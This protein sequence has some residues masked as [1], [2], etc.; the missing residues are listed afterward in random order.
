MVNILFVTYHDFSSN[1]AI[2]IHN[3]ANTLVKTG[4]HCCVAVPANKESVKECIGGDILYIPLNYS[5]LD[6]PGLFPNGNG[7][8]II[9]AWTPREIV[10]KQCI[11]SLNKFHCKLI[12]HLEDNEELLLE[13]ALSTSIDSL[14]TYTPEKLNEIIPD[15]LSHLFFYRDFI[16]IADGITVIMDTLTA[17]IPY[18]KKYLILWPGTDRSRFNP[19]EHN[20]NLKNE[21]GIRKNELILC[22]TGNVHFSNAKEVRSLYLA[23][24]LLNREGIPTR[25]I[26]TGKDFTNFL[27]NNNEWAHKFSIEMGFLPHQKISEIL[28]I[29]DILVQ[30]GKQDRFNEFRLPSKLPEFFFMGKPVILPY[31]N[32]GRFIKNRK[33]GLLLEKGDAID[34]VEK[35]N[36]LIH[37]K[38]LSQNIADG[39]KEFAMKKFDLGKNTKI[40]EDFYKEI[41]KGNSITDDAFSKYSEL[42]EKYK[43]YDLDEVGYAK[44]RDFCDSADNFKEI[45]N[46]DGDLKNVQRSWM[47][48]AILASVPF[49]GKL[50]EIGAGEPK[51]ADLLNRLGYQVTVID[52][53]EGG[54]NGPVE[55]EYFKKEY[56]NLKIIKDYFE[57]GIS[58][59]DAR[60]YDCV[61]SISVLEHIPNEQIPL[62]FKGIKKIAKPEGFSIHCIDHVLMGNGAQEHDEKLRSILNE[63]N[64]LPVFDRIL[65]QLKEDI[66]TYY[67]SAEGHNLWRGLTKYDDFP[68]RK[69]VSVQIRKKL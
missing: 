47:I 61:Y 50:V 21:L 14:K 24:A 4:N 42:F 35:V 11:T 49:G 17:F 37:D 30:P 34:I 51:V 38:K 6:Q 23:V 60:S 8:D 46:T 3:F 18:D 29:A 40:L 5:D 16:K 22:Y 66:E 69:V 9:H 15:T 10:R 33:E 7:P 62:I 39:G 20:N 43:D 45:C 2:Q 1:S 65:H 55:Y 27:G 25:L 52:P 19:S 26:R 13:N 28:N 48:K 64:L 44:V 36:L 56:S 58:V 63:N 54:G 57:N 53:Y 59:L 31:A 32:V 67:L 12:V 41:I 68:F